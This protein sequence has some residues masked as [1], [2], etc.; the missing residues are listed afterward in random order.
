MT[1]AAEVLGLRD[2]LEVGRVDAEPVPAE[3]VELEPGRDGVDE[4]LVGEAVRGDDSRR[5]S[6]E[7]AVAARGDGSAPVPAEERGID[8]L[9]EA[10]ECGRVARR[11]VRVP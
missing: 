1:G 3:V 9:E 4:L 5:I 7:A 6:L 2:R 11:H 10:V 8:L